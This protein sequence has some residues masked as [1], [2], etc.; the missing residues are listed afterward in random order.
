MRQTRQTQLL[1]TVGND[2]R[3]TFVGSFLRYYKLD[4]LPS[5]TKCAFR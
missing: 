1:L 2:K 4:E 3:V 5:V